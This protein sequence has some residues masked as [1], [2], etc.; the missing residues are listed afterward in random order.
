M[1]FSKKLTFVLFFL[2]LS[3]SLMGNSNKIAD[4]QLVTGG[5]FLFQGTKTST[6]HSAFQPGGRFDLTAGVIFI[7]SVALHFGLRSEFF[8]PSSFR[9][10]RNLKGYTA[11][12]PQF[13]LFYRHKVHETSKAS[14][15][16]GFQ[17]GSA[18]LLARYNLLENRFFYPTLDTQFFL[19]CRL[20]HP[21]MVTLR[22]YLPFCVSFRKDTKIC[23]NSGIGFSLL[24]DNFIL[25]KKAD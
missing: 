1:N 11:I 10:E 3:F 16:P 25:K 19:D 7:D 15:Y 20:H 18:M 13:S 6:D 22:V 12:G 2:S 21:E 23:L 14:L 24:L 4:F 5:S 8:A 9:N 17:V